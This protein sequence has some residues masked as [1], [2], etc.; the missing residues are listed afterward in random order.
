MFVKIVAR[1]HLMK[2]LE[3]YVEEHS[4]VVTFCDTID[5]LLQMYK[6]KDSVQDTITDIDF[7][8]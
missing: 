1:L 2:E 5:D 3:E 4:E 7:D 8:V 6:N